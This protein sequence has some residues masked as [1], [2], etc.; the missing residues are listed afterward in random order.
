MLFRSNTPV[1]TYKQYEDEKLNPRIADLS[2]K[3]S[4]MIATI[5]GKPC[6]INI[7]SNVADAYQKGVLPLNTLANAVLSKYDAQQSLAAQNYEQHIG[8]EETNNQQRVL[9]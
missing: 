1:R 6:V 8:M 2:M 4:S 9:K 7:S 5:D 3:G